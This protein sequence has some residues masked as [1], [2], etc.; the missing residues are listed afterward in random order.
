M[1]V[2]LSHETQ[3]SVGKLGMRSGARIRP[4]TVAFQHGAP[5]L[6]EDLKSDSHYAE[7]APNYF[8]FVCE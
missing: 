5:K 8:E 1:L 7:G 4:Q 3:A 2:L 6:N